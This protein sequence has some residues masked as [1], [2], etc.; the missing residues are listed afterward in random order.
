M[1]GEELDLRKLRYFVEVAERGTLSEAG[2]RLGLTQP[3]LG[4]QV[5]VVEDELGWEWFERG[6][7]KLKLTKEGGVVLREGRRLLKAAAGARE[8]MRREIEGVELRV[9]YA[10]SLAGGMIEGAMRVF[11]Q[12]HPQVKVMLRDSSTEEMRAGLREG[13]LDLVVEVA[14]EEPGI[15]WRTLRERE[16]RLAV[17]EEHRLARKRKVKPQDLDGERMILLSR[18]DYP[19][20]WEQVTSYFAEHGANAKVAGEFDG[21]ASLR[22][23][24]EAGMGVA[25]VVEGA[26]V[27]RG[28]KMVR[29]DPG[30]EL[31]SVAVGWAARQSLSD[32][33]AAFVAELERAARHLED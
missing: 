25:L 22:M 9:G 29:L 16:F 30:P 2:R 12:L 24:L 18:V 31:L 28:V 13:T 15:R 17:P 33:E 26:A 5:R 10:P 11:C 32:W 4:R 8:R 7:R 6:G 21:I 1:I 27:G 19:G 20:Y 14:T 23:G 3:A